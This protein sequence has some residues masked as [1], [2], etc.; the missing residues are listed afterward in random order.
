MSRFS[1]EPDAAFSRRLLIVTASVLFGVCL[2]SSGLAQNGLRFIPPVLSSVEKQRNDLP[3]P[4]QRIQWDGGMVPTTPNVSSLTP[5]KPN[6]TPETLGSSEGMIPL[7]PS[8]THRSQTPTLNFDPGAPI[9]WENRKTSAVPLPP[10]INREELKAV[11]DRGVELEKEGHWADTLTHYESALR[12]FH[13]EPTL[14]ER[15]RCARFHY[16]IDRRMH[17]A[18]YLKIFTSSSFA[19]V[20]TLFEEIISNIQTGYVD[21]PHWNELF[22]YGVQDLEIALADPGFRV[23]TGLHV[24]N[25]KIDAYLETVRQ[26]VAGWEIRN[27]DDLR[28]GI[29]RLA[30][31]GQ[32]QIGLNPSV[33]LL[34]FSCGI[35]NS[36]DP[37]TSYLTPNQLNETSSMISGNF[38]GLGVEL[39][40]DRESLIIVR[41][42]SGSPAKEAGL[43]NGDRII[44]VDGIATKGQD[45][46]RAA[47]M[48]QGEENS[49]VRLTVQTSGTAPRDLQIVRRRIEVASVEDVHLL[50]PGVGYIRLT[51]FQTK[52]SQEMRKA[53]WDLNRQGMQTLVLDMRHNPGGLLQVGVEVANLFIDSGTILRTRKRG[54]EVETPF[55]AT[56]EGTWNGLQLIVLI[57][58]ESA[59][60]SEIVAGALRDH[61]RAVLVGKRSFGK[62]TI[63]AII[64]M[65]RKNPLAGGL[66]LTTEK[67]YSPNGLPFS[68]V[69]VTP[70]VLVET[71]EKVVVGRPING[72]IQPATRSITSS[73]NDPFIRQALSVAK[74][75]R[76]AN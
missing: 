17:D 57:D 61:H 13:G 51:G 52:T 18:S 12:A 4:T 22:Q 48:L 19:D 75:L 53:L 60:A 46:S 26:T 63:Q 65:T 5:V 34:E 30:E 68:E 49:V 70:H 16:D 42:I 24:P 31:I 62:G 39:K 20:L 25:D 71:G 1:Y 10:P 7:Q 44:S 43:L 23:L 11:L 33:A 66:R 15:F 54:G 37:Y 3:S 27:R 8:T 14:L 32:Q 76:Q 36:L 69:G 67:F 29:L 55:V 35:T 9:R 47:D 41:V 56:A 73:P 45:T 28:N 38:V 40:S 64:S 2:S 6:L 59:S 58:E 74:D 72:R 21:L 50:E